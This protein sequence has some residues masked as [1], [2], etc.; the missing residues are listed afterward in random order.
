MPL[1]SMSH[2]LAKLSFVLLLVP[3]VA[4]ARAPTSMSSQETGERIRYTINGGWMFYPDGLEFGEKKFVSDAGWE[5]VT[6]PHTWNASDPFDD[7]DS[8]R[9]GISW[10]RRPLQ[11]DE[12]LAGKQIFLY[13]E[14]VNQVADVYV[15]GA[16]AGHHKGGY[17]AFTI[18]ITDLVT[19]DN[20]NLIAVEVDNSHDP[21]I[22]PLSVGFALYGGIYR[23]VWL[24]ATDP[25]HVKVTDHA[26]SGVYISTPRVS[27]ERGE[28]RVRGTIVNDAA[29][30]QQVRV[31][32]TVLNAMGENVAE[33]ESSISIRGGGEASFA[34]DV[35]PIG[36]PR[37]WSPED[38]YLYTVE[39][40]V[41]VGSDLRDRIR[42]PL[43]FRWFHFDPDHGFFLNG[44][45][46]QLRG[47]NRH[48][49]YQG[50]G[51]ALSNRQHVQDL[52]WIKEMGANF[53]RLAHYPQDPRVLEA[54]DRLGLLVWEEAPVVNYITVSEEFDRNSMNMLREMIRQ[55]YNH[56]SVILWGTMNE[57]FLW[58]EQG[59]RIGRQ[60]D[61]TYMRQVRDFAAK[62]DALARAE[63]PSRY[64][65]MA[66]HGS[67][68][69]DKVGIADIPQVLGL[70]TYSGWYGGEFE[71]YGRSL[72][73]RHAENPE[74]VIVISEYGSGSDLRLN[75]LVPERFDHSSAWHR[76]YHESYLRQTRERPY[77]AGTGIWNQFDFSQPHIGESMPN[78]N[79]K[80]MLTW[81]R[82]P[83]DVFYMYKANWNPEPMVYI[84]SRDW[85]H[86]TG[87]DPEAAFGAGPVPV[88]QPVDVYS[89]LDRVELFVNGRSLGAV[90]PDDVQKASWQVPFGDGDN[91]LEARAEVDGRV[92]TDRLEIDFDYYPP[93]LRDPSVPFEQIAV[94]V[95]SNAQYSDDDG[96]VWEAD[97][98]YSDGGFGHIGGERVLMART[99]LITGTA[100][101]GMYVTYR[102]G[103]EGYRFD[104]PDGD[105]RVELLFAEPEDLAPGERVFDV[106]MNGATM[107]ERVDLAEQTGLGR[108]NPILI[109]TAV[110]GGAGL[111]VSFG[112]VAGEPI[113]NGIRVRKR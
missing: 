98:P 108:A 97:Q 52:E 13:F 15:N 17:T 3:L 50:L 16:F 25:L 78:M 34:H 83:K 35:P 46:L 64:T 43:G 75:A 21:F 63:D 73:R 6:I 72:D 90:E 36:N 110:R 105:Y 62:M 18:E 99:V 79:Q 56:P 1:I 103:L 32:N 109:D 81:D 112:V 28:V 53:L 74:Q 85:T 101:T 77:V 9:R 84:A 100:K 106:G 70:N 12:S 47:T 27:R 57:V 93:D 45:S 80:G 89:N 31:V 67:D 42:N 54:A 5:A 88:T 24:V 4:A 22:P 38:P 30:S 94:N 7:E 44:E 41:Y 96:L 92:H 60:T 10:Y 26:S 61:T 55:H 111:L 107:L 29:E 33:G 65:A 91:V 51:S 95:G 66:I 59:A 113:L 39:T 69:Y 40:R 14:G 23:D 58:S 37:L 49:D 76:M 102:A 86:R 2:F 71:G 19:F 104:V 11:L 82:Q 20:E 8:Y 48:Q 87:T 68:D